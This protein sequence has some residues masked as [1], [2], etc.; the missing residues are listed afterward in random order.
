MHHLQNALAHLPLA[1]ST[2]LFHAPS[3]TLSITPPP[4]PLEGST[5]DSDTE[6]LDNP[7]TL[8][9]AFSDRCNWQ[10]LAANLGKLLTELR[11]GS[12]ADLA[13][14][15]GVLESRLTSHL[16]TSTLPVCEG[17]TYAVRHNLAP[18]AQVKVGT[19][20]S[21]SG[22]TTPKSF[23]DL[24]KLY[25]AAT[26]H[27]HTHPLG[28]FSGAMSWPVP[29]EAKDKQTI[30]DLL[31]APDPTLPDLPL[32]DR[33]GALGYLLSASNLSSND[34]KFPAR[35]VE[36]LLG[37]A[38]A[39]ALGQ[40]IQAR[41]GGIATHTSINDYL[42]AAIQLGLDP[43]SMGTPAR[44]SVGGFDLG[45][46]ALWNQPPSATIE[47]LSRHLVKEARTPAASA[48]LAA[49]MLLART[50][51]E[52][53]VKGIPPNVTYGSIPWTQLAIAAAKLEAQSPGCVLTMTYSEV[54]AAAEGLD[55]GTPLS[56]HIHREA[57]CNWAIVN[58]HLK[59][60]PTPTD[61]EMRAVQDAFSIQQKALQATALALA[62]PIPMRENMGMDLLREKFPG[63][64]DEVF[65][66]KNLTKARLIKGRPGIF[67]G[68]H[69][70]LDVVMHGDKVKNDDSEHWI[71]KDTRIPIKQFCALSDSGAL[72]VVDAFN[73]QYT[74]A[75][76]AQE[77]G[78]TGMTQY[79]ISTLPPQDRKNFEYGQLEFFHTNDYVIGPDFSTKS[80]IKKGHTLDVKITRDGQ[81]NIY[82]I[83]TRAGS[84]T[85]HN[86]LA[87]IYSPPYSRLDM[88]DANTLHRTVR[89]NPFEDEHT[90][91]AKEKP[92][93]A[94]TPKVFDSDRTR[95]IAKVLTKRLDLLGKDLLEHARGTTSYDKTSAANKAIGEFFL[96]LIPFRSAIVNFMQGNIGDGLLDLGMDVMGLVTLGS[97]KAAHASKVLT[98][99]VAGLKGAA[100]TARFLGTVA[101][102]VLNP[103]GGAGDLL[104]GIS[105][106]TWSKGKSAFNALKG[107]SGS[108]DV[109]KAAST[110]HGLVAVGTSKV[111]GH[112]L[113]MGAVFRG[114][115]WHAFDSVK[116]V[117]YGPPLK[118]FQPTVAAAAGEVKVLN[119]PS[120]LGYEAVIDPDLLQVKGMQNNVYVGP[121]NKE[122]IKIDNKLYASTVKDGQRVIQHPSA[123]HN[124][125][126][127]KDLGSAGWEVS[128]TAN[129]LLGGVPDALPA[130][131]LDDKTYV[132][133]MDDIKVNAGASSYPY[134]I[135]YE[136]D[137][138]ATSF[139]TKVGAWVAGIG[140][141]KGASPQY[142]WRSAKN[143]WQKG[144]LEE[145]RNAKKIANHT[146]RFV[147]FVQPAILQAPKN[148]RPI[149]KDIHYF[150]A[151]GDIPDHLV[152]N[153][154][155]NRK[156]MPDFKSTV[157]VDADTPALFQAIKLK[158]AKDAPS[159]TVLNLHEDDFF[160][161]LKNTELYSYFRRGQG[162]NL[163]A[164]SD[165]ARYPLMNKY[166]GIYL[167]TD[168]LIQG[169]IGPIALKADD[170]E[171]LVSTPVAITINDYKPCINTS[172]FATQPNN[173]LIAQVISEMNRRFPANKA[174]FKANRP[175]VPRDA[176]G[177]Y[178]LTPEFQ[179]YEIKVFETVGPLMFDDVLKSTRPD[180][181]DL[182]FDGYSKE[183]WYVDGK[184]ITP[185]KVLD[186]GTDFREYFEQKGI[187]W[188]D[189]LQQ[190]LTDARLRYLRFNKNLSIKVGSENSWIDT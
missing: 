183:Q 51:P 160:E 26:Q 182:A 16:N 62:T 130:W 179:A 115:N 27:V 35:A 154:V 74:P 18:T 66:A 132:L 72:S 107:A 100:R 12:P 190:N 121:N 138:Y 126:K 144:S 174:Y 125:I 127:V 78:H 96:N 176:Q 61:T 87:H 150:W 185:E 131:K 180:L 147:E 149:P 128:V 173:P 29:L 56:Q 76:E 124:D 88:R 43:Q 139:D 94:E 23:D 114:G 24:L 163:A 106:W 134:T 148:V 39:Q 67:P 83:D 113:E 153:M 166:G 84:I 97:A 31:N 109:L 8:K 34:F 59:A 146:F 118:N 52:Y 64:P 82:R 170:G 40:A 2:A 111:V 177:A 122:Y 187:V 123:P 47:G 188:S 116:G 81:V 80:L 63:V 189:D 33:K 48:E 73:Q 103:L 68:S 69:S 140:I 42:L 30:I 10:A 46:R 93:I 71:T 6:V 1:N 85:K 165:V 181:H 50:A 77:K 101:I 32:V 137:S 136:G 25:H 117:P 5:S 14:Q 92:T 9:R 151:G 86:Y 104:K 75:M 90:E 38:K 36:M 21:G 152:K 133:P 54:L 28:N 141:G 70:M 13:D 41:L 44:N 60:E 168:D 20:L 58:G 167:D 164:S 175:I 98:K 129:R 57:L 79:L 178:T 55:V 17:S 95:Y 3:P 19:F 4:L 65:K 171:I 119:K 102:D 159:V 162:Q 184:K 37:S 120:L 145:Y 158:L 22:L 15:Q 135:K 156:K 45:Q 49:H 99:G 108:Y 142:F 186:A 157:H 105:R 155:A 53:L 91:Q 7:T 172:N 143:T 112:D 161:Q 89:F 169:H 11:E 110:Q